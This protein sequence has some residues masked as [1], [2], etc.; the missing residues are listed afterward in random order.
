[1]CSVRKQGDDEDRMELSFDQICKVINDLCDMGIKSIR[2][3]GAEPLIRKELIDII[4]HIKSKNIICDLATNG[5]LI[6]KEMAKELVSSKI[7]QI[8]LSVDAPNELH[9]K[10]RGVKG[11]FKKVMEGL[12]YLSFEKKRDES[13]VPR[14]NV[15]TTISSVNCSIE[16]LTAMVEFIE[17]NEIE[18]F[19]FGLIRETP[20]DVVDKTVFKGE[21]IGTT[22]FLPESDS[23]L[24]DEDSLMKIKNEAAKNPALKMALGEINYLSYDHLLKGTVP[25]KRCYQTHD[26]ILINPYGDVIPCANLDRYV[27]GNVL[28]EDIQDIW[29]SSA[30]TELTDHLGKTFFPMCNY[31]CHIQYTPLQVL[32]TIFGLKF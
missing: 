9:D 18:S 13:S 1:M 12:H 23:L 26:V 7:D 6:T 17:R 8:A 30:H 20:L 29:K 11:A 10:V 25:I 2:L 22:R 19:S 15:R 21:K 27:F 4:K 31:C 32:K 3:I 28:K 14:F 16:N 5:T 24:L